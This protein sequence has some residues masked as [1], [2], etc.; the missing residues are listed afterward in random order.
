MV[1]PLSHEY[2]GLKMSEKKIKINILTSI[3]LILILAMRYP[4]PHNR[5][6]C[7]DR[8]PTLPLDICNMYLVFCFTLFGTRNEK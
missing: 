1:H 4:V 5:T 6:S 7:F 8:I 3:E 2:V